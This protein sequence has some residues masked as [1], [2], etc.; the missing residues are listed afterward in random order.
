MCV[1]ALCV[2]GSILVRVCIYAIGGEGECVC[3]HAPFLSMPLNRALGE[4]ESV[5]VRVCVSVCVCVCVCMCA[6]V[7][8]RVCVRSRCN[9]LGGASDSAGIRQSILTLNCRAQEMYGPSE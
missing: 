4:G 3:C 6:S 9:A 7:F 2:V 5:C 1:C 8:V